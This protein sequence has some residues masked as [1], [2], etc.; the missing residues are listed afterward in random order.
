MIT[1]ALYNNKG[2]VGKTTAVVNLSYLAA[3]GGRRTLVCDLDSQASA[4][5]YLRG[6]P[7]LEQAACGLTASAPIDRSIQASEYPNLDLLPAD[8]THRQL[9][10]VLDKLEDP[11]HRLKE[12]LEPLSSRYDLIVLDCP[13]TLNVLAE[14]IFNAADHLLAPIIPTILSVRTYAQL[15]AFLELKSYDL[16]SV[17]TF[18]SMVDRRKKMHTETMQAASEAFDGVLQS[19]IPYRSDVERMG[20]KRQPLSV[21][22]PSSDA[23]Q[24][25]QDLWRELEENLTEH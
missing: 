18:F 1:L 17:H 11:A 15:L 13:S 19:S 25:F 12:L 16:A 9:D 3:L 8:F 24:A 4:T 21:F 6:K 7:G 5:Y 20:L 10:T 14:N 22:A 23:T 2:G